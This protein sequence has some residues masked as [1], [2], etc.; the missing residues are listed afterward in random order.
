M[1]N[2]EMTKSISKFKF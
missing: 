1:A 2:I